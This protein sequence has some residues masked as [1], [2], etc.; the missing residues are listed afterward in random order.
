MNLQSLQSDWAIWLALAMLLLA[1]ATIAPRLLKM[2][3]RSKLGRVFADVK[4]ARKELRKATRALQKAARRYDRLV[5]RADRVKPR[6]LQE[7][8]ESVQDAQALVK[9]LNDKVLVAETHV[10]RIIYDEFPPEKHER[11]RAKYLPQDV[12]DN[13]PFSF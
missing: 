13:R 10:R 4:K 3:S 7:A 6:V 8:E 9:I 1:A 11:M 5:A 12:I 2:T